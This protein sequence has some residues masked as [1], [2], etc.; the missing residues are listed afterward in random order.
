MSTIGSVGSSSAT[1]V[2]PETQA[3]PAKTETKSTPEIAANT[4]VP[5]DPKDKMSDLKMEGQT[6]E[7][8]VRAQFQASPQ[9]KMPGVD[10]KG[11]NLDD[12]KIQDGF[13][14]FDKSM[15]SV[16]IKWPEKGE[17]KETKDK[18]GA[19][20][21]EM[22]DANGTSFKEKVD[23]NGT[24]E[25]E[26]I[27]KDGN[28]RFELT[29]SKGF[30]MRGGAADKN[31]SWS[32]DSNGV[33]TRT[34]SDAEGRQF[35]ESKTES[36]RHRE[37]ID[38]NGNFHKERLENSG[39]L[40]R[41]CGDGQGNRQ[42]EIREKGNWMKGFTDD[43]GN[44]YSVNND[45]MSSRMHHDQQSGKMYLETSYKDGSK[46]RQIGEK[47]GDVYME[48]YDPNGKRTVKNFKQ[49]NGVLAQQ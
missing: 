33:T 12:P 14:Q 10:I 34:H 21:R 42:F 24:R 22:T 28:R 5:Q 15:P 39:K 17:F 1:A 31:N 8:Q 20:L 30:T 19:T 45:G 36:G 11:P 27:D 48:D 44:S 2:L 6:R 32:I 49:E 41:E 18:D 26:S 47:N 29:D 43:K 4:T 7:A 35:I 25:R 9:F 23:K 46:S 37:T 13:K 40:E 3:T 38:K 16:D